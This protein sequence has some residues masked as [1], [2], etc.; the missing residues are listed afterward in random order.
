[1]EFIENYRKD[2]SYKDDKSLYEYKSS[3]FSNNGE[4]F[5]T[6]CGDNCYRIHPVRTPERIIK[7]RSQEY[8]TGLIKSTHH[9]NVI[10][11]SFNTRG[12]INSLGILSFDTKNFLS[13]F[14]GH[15]DEIVSID[16]NNIDDT[17][18]STSRDYSFMLWS[19]NQKQHLF[20]TYFTSCTPYACFNADGTKIL[21]AEYDRIH[22]LDIKKSI[23]QPMKTIKVPIRDI[24]KIT[25][26]YDDMNITVS[27][28]EGGIAIVENYK[29][30]KKTGPTIVQLSSEER[31]ISPV[32]KFTNDSSRLLYSSGVRNGINVYEIDTGAKRMLDESHTSPIKSIECNP[33]YAIIS[34]CSTEVTWWNY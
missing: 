28:T 24:T 13:T 27:S 3:T 1:M 11:T 26:S 5:V 14:H 12:I 2:F 34:A 18:M 21:L 16:F 17:F 9:Q 20:K 22:V 19:Q 33:K 8:G 4:L 23:N 30:N 32:I 7:L 10:L 31:Q 6:S 29:T 15:T 25:C